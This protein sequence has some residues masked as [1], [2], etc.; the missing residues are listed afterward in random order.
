MRIAVLSD[1]HGNL[2]A[3]E[4]VAA[5]IGR[6]KPDAVIHLGD[7][8]ASGHR[9]AEV[10]D[11]VQA[12]GWAGVYGNT[13]EMLWRPELED[14]LARRMPERKALRRVLFREIAPTTR[15]LLGTERLEWLQALPAVI[16]LGDWAFFHAS[17]KDL[18]K[19]PGP[20]ASEEAL[21]QIL[22]D[23]HAST[24]VYGHIHRQFYRSIDG[25]RV[26]NAGSASLSY[27][28]DARAH[29]I[30]LSEDECSL[31]LVDY[32]REA[33]VRDLLASG[34]PRA[35]WLASMLQ[36]GCFS[37]PPLLSLLTSACDCA[38]PPR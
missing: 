6:E 20:D 12:L 17:P 11:L 32:E 31:R 18:W 3:L 27:S 5:D 15:A 4:A 38:D 36:S 19:A 1:V 37:E 7:L 35:R 9:P 22:A 8:V 28:G 13:D 26:A 29:Y 33:E 10:I 21:R 16:H 30:L 24:V 34:F 2:R 14:E 23:A 25:A